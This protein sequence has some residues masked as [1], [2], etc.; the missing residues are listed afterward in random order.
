[1][2]NEEDILSKTEADSGTK[3]RNQKKNVRFSLFS[4]LGSD[5]MQAARNYQHV[6]EACCLHL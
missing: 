2:R 4:L 1:V 5:S 3:T 6:R